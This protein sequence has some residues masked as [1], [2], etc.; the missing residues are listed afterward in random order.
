VLGHDA[1]SAVGIDG[2]SVQPMRDWKIALSEVMPSII[3]AVKA[4]G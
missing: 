3:S 1:W 4:E 2:V